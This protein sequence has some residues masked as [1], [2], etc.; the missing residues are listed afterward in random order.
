M[1]NDDLTIVIITLNEAHNLNRFFDSIE[2]WVSNIV[3][4]D[5]F[6]SDNTID[7]CISRGAKVFQRKFDNFGS[8]WNVA[9]SETNIKTPWVMKMDPDEVMKNEL[10][11]NINEALKQT[12]FDAFNLVMKNFFMGKALPKN[13]KHLRIW[14]NGK[15]KFS[16]S[17]VNEHPIVEGLIGDI[18]GMYEHHDS[19]DLNHWLNKQNKYTASEAEALVNQLSLPFK[20]NLLGSADQRRMFYKKYFYSI[21]FRYSILFIYHY[22]VL[23][24]YRLGKVGLI[25]SRLRTLVYYLTELKAFELRQQNKTEFDLLSYKVGSPDNR[26]EQI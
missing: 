22:L 19:P 21:P 4:L 12:K 10:K 15:C 3:V 14:R 13:F 26:C 5:S 16:D 8:Q 7:I 11:I 1:K 6:S 18:E 24:A 25:W 2:G 23:G 17:L 20:P 9:I